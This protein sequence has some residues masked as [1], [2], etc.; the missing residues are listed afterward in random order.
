MYCGKVLGLLTDAADGVHYW[1]VLNL[2][3]RKNKRVYGIFQAK[4]S[5]AFHM[6]SIQYLF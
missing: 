4:T 6:V 5:W 2:I 1:K 3:T